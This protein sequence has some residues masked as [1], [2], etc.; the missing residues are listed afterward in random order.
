MAVYETPGTQ[1]FAETIVPYVKDCNTIILANHGTV[2]FGPTWK[3]PTS[4]PRSS[5]PIAKS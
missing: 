3:T 2:T 5:T 4:T 1:K